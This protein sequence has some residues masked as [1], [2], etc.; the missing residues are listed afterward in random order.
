MVVNQT[1]SVV[2]RHYL[3]YIIISTL[4]HDCHVALHLT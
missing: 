2:M 1:L 4:S 3:C